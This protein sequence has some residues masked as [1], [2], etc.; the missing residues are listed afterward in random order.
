MMSSPVKVLSLSLLAALVAAPV[1]APAQ[2]Q[3]PPA[4]PPAADAGDTDVVEVGG[5][6]RTLPKV[7]FLPLDSAS[8]ATA[9]ELARLVAL[10]G[11]YATNTLAPGS[12]IAGAAVRV[13][14]TTRDRSQTVEVRTTTGQGEEH[15]RI[16]S[17]EEPTRDIDSARLADAIVADLTGERSHLS[18]Q[19]IHVDASQPGE[20]RVRVMLASGKPV[21]DVSPA[22]LFARGA[23]TY[24]GGAVHY[25]GGRQGEPLRLYREG[26]AQ[27][28]K[29]TPE[30]YVQAVAFALD[31]RAA[32]VAGDQGNTG[33]WTGFLGGTMQRV[34]ADAEMV[35]SP[36]FGPTGQL[37][38][39]TGPSAGPLRVVVD[40]KPVSQAGVWASSPSF[41]GGPTAAGDKAAPAR[42]AYMVKQ[43]TNWG[44]MLADLTSGGVQGFGSGM[45]PICSPD[46]RS[47]AVSRPARGK[48][49]GAVWIVGSGGLGANVAREGEMGGG[50]WMPGP[51]LPPEGLAKRIGMW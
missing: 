36:S 17:F 51:P 21:R 13:G 41:C 30:G 48:N 5:A 34:H 16:L 50:R 45:F 44:V 31:G 6:T 35:I 26:Q 37:A 14:L 28:V 2:A 46:G 39:A 32:V 23:D 29:V 18:G 49:K 20:R 33:L 25:A 15:R 1:V 40:G 38:Y 9:R 11:L 19:L 22:G 24:P 12:P 47:I 8:Q 4:S 3:S 7:L 43:G 10:T 27:P 42:L